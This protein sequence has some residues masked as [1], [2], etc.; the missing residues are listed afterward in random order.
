M[1]T[2]VKMPGMSGRQLAEVLAS[3]HPDMKVLFMSGY[4]DDSTLQ[5]GVLNPG[6]AFLQK[7]FTPAALARKIRDL[8]DSPFTAAAGVPPS[9]KSG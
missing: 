8:L 1:V 3:T 4:T 5:H 7:P 2:D 9:L 6:T